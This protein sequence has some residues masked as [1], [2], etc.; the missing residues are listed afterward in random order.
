[1]RLDR[2]LTRLPLLLLALV[3]T[4][5]TGACDLGPGT[6]PTTSTGPSAPQSPTAPPRPSSTPTSPS[7]PATRPSSTFQ[8]T[9][10][11]RPTA[12]RPPTASPGSGPTA[13]PDPSAGA[14]L[15]QLVGQKLIVAMSGT[16]PSADLLGRIRRG[17]V[18]GVILFGANISTAAQVRALTSALRGA[19]AAAGRPHLLI[20]VDQEGGQI[21]RIPWIGPT[22]APPDLGELDDPDTARAQGLST[23]QALRDLGIDLD[24]APVVDVPVS[25]DAFIA[26]QGRAYSPS[27]T[28]TADMADA[29]AAGLR[30]AGVQPAFKH[31]PGLGLAMANTDTTF[32]TIEA[33]A[34]ELAP[35]LVPYRAAI[36]HDTAPLIMLSNA[37]YPA[38]DEGAAAG[39]SRAIGV[40]LLR[41]ELGFRGATMTDSL[42]GAAKSRGVTVASLAVRAA[43]AGT[44]LILT[45]GSEAATAGVYAALLAQAKAGAIPRATLITSYAR[46]MA[47][48]G[49]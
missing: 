36:A 40:D 28:I 15:A 8:P 22:I 20:A 39:W 16:S 47:L 41:G 11:P 48:K 10:S 30:A 42:D 17:E 25:D 49:S 24:L 46:I 45:T 34:T 6:S 19:A 9:S 4:C 14:S 27:P 21:K 31:F 2:T 26:R 18:G 35:G 32:V 1:M 33:S 3:L 23:G 44:D 38:L 7:S 13:T 12:S 43:L 29:F 37:V 5:A